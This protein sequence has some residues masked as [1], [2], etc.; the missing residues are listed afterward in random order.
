MKTTTWHRD[1]PAG[2][3][4]ERTE[5]VDRP[6]CENAEQQTDTNNKQ[7]NELGLQ[8]YRVDQIVWNGVSEYALQFVVFLFV[9]TE[10]DDTKFTGWENWK[11]PNGLGLKDQIPKPKH[12]KETEVIF[13]KNIEIPKI[14]SVKRG[15][16]L[17]EQQR[18][19]KAGCRLHLSSEVWLSHIDAY[20][21]FLT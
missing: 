8:K 9:Y 10:E 14:E 19:K 21:Y 17:E 7:S 20:Q 4:E 18:R 1:G 13:R 6:D 11:A 12:H 2:I 16:L 15:R 3:T 5:R